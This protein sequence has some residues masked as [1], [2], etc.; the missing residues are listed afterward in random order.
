MK[1]GGR[2]GPPSAGRIVAHPVL[3]GLRHEYELAARGPDRNLP[4]HRTCGRDSST[5]NQIRVITG[6]HRH[7]DC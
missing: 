6:G 2:A 5:M 7:Q 3:G 4:P 1:V